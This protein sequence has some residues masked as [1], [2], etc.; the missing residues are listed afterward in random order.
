[1]KQVLIIPR[2][3]L[4]ERVISS[5]TSSPYICALIDCFNYPEI[6]IILF[7]RTV[8]QSRHR[9]IQN[10]TPHTSTWY[11]Q[12]N[13]SIQSSVLLLSKVSLKSLSKER[14]PIS[15]T[16]PYITTQ[17]SIQGQDVSLTNSHNQRS[18]P[19]SL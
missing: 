10:I 9:K 11:H 1:M 15:P 16:S 18:L 7:C 8:Q 14:S 3:K 2:Y 19:Q 5:S 4:K 6:N 12:S 13:Q 17:E